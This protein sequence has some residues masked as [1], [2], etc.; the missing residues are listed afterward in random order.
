MGNPAACIRRRRGRRRPPPS[1]P[2]RPP[3]RIHTSDQRKSG[4]RQRPAGSPSRIPRGMD[5]RPPGR[6]PPAREPGPD[7]SQA[8]L[9]RLA[10][11]HAMRVQAQ[12]MTDRHRPPPPGSRDPKSWKPPP[13]SHAPPSRRHSRGRKPPPPMGPP[14]ESAIEAAKQQGLHARPRQAPQPQPSPSAKAV[15]S[16]IKSKKTKRPKALVLTV[17]ESNSATPRRRTMT[18]GKVSERKRGPGGGDPLRSQYQRMKMMRP[19][20]A[21]KTRGTPSEEDGQSFLSWWKTAMP[22]KMHRARQAT[23]QI[24]S[25]TTRVY[26]NPEL[27]MARALSLERRGLPVPQERH[28]ICNTLE[29]AR[30][31]TFCVYACSAEELVASSTKH[32]TFPR[33]AWSQSKKFQS[34][35][36]TSGSKW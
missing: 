10:Q 16:V 32:C 5:S 17:D 8:Q 1:P 23:Q 6:K 29:G 14:P 13:P 7:D 2:H 19:R 26:R 25:G 12:A 28:E 35:R 27:S 24:H 20:R 18:R 33:S 22:R 3:A 30:G 4:R 21:R 34:L 11:R 36:P 15:A 31:T 9:I